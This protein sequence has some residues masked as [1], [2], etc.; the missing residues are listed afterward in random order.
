MKEHY[1]S[2][3]F[4]SE[5]KC[6]YVFDDENMQQIEDY[7]NHKSGDVEMLFYAAENS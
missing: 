5:E 3:I 2:I 6:W 1:I 4:N 7:I